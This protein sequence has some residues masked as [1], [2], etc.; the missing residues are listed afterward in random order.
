MPYDHRISIEYYKMFGQFERT[1]TT[2]NLYTNIPARQI[3][4]KS[5]LLKMP[6]VF[7]LKFQMCCGYAIVT[8]HCF[9][10]ETYPANE[11]TISM[12]VRIIIKT[13]TPDREKADKKKSSQYV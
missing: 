8:V 5:D 6:R 2:E 4:S 7:D 9:T 1:T 10:I 3:R 11:T 13:S 12:D